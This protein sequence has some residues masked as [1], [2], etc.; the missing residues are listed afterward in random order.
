MFGYLLSIAL[1]LNVINVIKKV[2][3]FFMLSDFAWHCYGYTAFL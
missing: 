3:F 2:F 1:P